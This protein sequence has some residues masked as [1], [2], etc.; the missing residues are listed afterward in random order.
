MTN[1]HRATPSTEPVLSAGVVIAL[2]EAVIVALTAFGVSISPEQHVAII[3]LVG[4]VLALAAAVLPALVAR[5][6]VT[7][8]SQVVE[9][10]AYGQVIAGAGHDTIAEGE[11]IRDVHEDA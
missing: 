3:G 10:R 5:S 6:K 11:K 1:T 2:V 9:Q 4:A 8:S 7:P